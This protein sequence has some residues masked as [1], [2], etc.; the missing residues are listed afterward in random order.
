MKLQF[1]FR[2]ITPL[3]RREKPK[4]VT[5]ATAAAYLRAARSRK[6]GNVL[7]TTPHLYRIIDGGC[8]LQPQP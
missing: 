3:N 2:W 1:T 6:R 8:V 7:N 4:P 5:R